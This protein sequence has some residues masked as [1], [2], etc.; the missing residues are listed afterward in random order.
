MSDIPLPSVISPAEIA[1]AAY[2]E[3]EAAYQRGDVRKALNHYLTALVNE[4]S[5]TLFRRG[6]LKAL[7]MVKGYKA[8]PANVIQALEACTAD[9]TLDLQ[10]IAR[11]AANMLRGDPRREA[12]H[13]LLS[14][15][16]DSFAKAVTDKSLD[17]V[18]THGLLIGALEHSIICDEDLETTLTALRRHVLRLAHA[19]D[20][21]QALQSYR[22]FLAALAR[23]CIITRHIWVEQPDERAHLATLSNST[24]ISVAERALLRCLY[25]PLSALSA[26][27][28]ETLPAV[29]REIVSNRAQEKELAAILPE[30]T[31]I[32]SG[33]SNSMKAQYEG[34]PYPPWKQYGSGIALTLNRFL[35]IY[36]PKLEYELPQTGVFDI[37][38]AG[39]GTGRFTNELARLMPFARL[40]AVDLSRASLGYAARMADI[41]GVKNVSFGVADIRML[42]SI[43]KRFSLIECGGVLHHMANPVEGLHILRDLLLPGGLIR[44]GLYS[45]RARSDITLARDFVM[46]QNLEDSIT[47]MRAARHAIFALPKTEPVRRVARRSDFYSADSFH[48]L[49]FNVHEIRFTP[50]SMKNMFAESGLIFLGMVVDHP[51]RRAQYLAANP[52]DPQCRDL[53]K[54]EEFEKAY[55]DT[56][57]GMFQ[58]WLQKPLDA[59]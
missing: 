28:A 17:W 51:L 24:T 14:A 2:A 43:P 50:L 8:L 11:I 48:D 34:F 15:Q 13:A 55:P 23:Q 56:F 27:E 40:R 3:G 49:V 9:P 19:R 37:L 16:D 52:D 59:A 21:W 42:G 36:V 32:S 12:L 25:E 4:P 57:N 33:M 45:D 31:P 41:N 1:A 10:P 5:R 47:G 29:L 38:I 22:P 46:A 44:I 54:W 39:C 20:G 58:M 7:E 6:A 26:D 35:E 30:V 53:D 18:F